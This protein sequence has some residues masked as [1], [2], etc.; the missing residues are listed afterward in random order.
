MS[1]DATAASVF[2]G[3]AASAA[4]QSAPNGCVL[5]QVD[6]A[7]VAAQNPPPQPIPVPPA[8]AAGAG[9]GL[10]PLLL[11]LGV[12]AAGVGLYLALHG[13][14]GGNDQPVSPA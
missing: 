12:L 2:C 13:G 11:A 4:A 1:A 7:P 8:E 10:S 3:A 9:F 5:P 6:A 14:G